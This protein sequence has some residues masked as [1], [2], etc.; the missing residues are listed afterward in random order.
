V[1]HAALFRSLRRARAILLG[2]K[3]FG[4]VRRRGS[5]GNV[6]GFAGNSV[7]YEDHCAGFA[8]DCVGCSG[9]GVGG[10]GWFES[11]ESHVL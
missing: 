11:Q 6:A 4:V 7:G 5:A 8:G 3:M 10:S 1:L 9:G 2:L